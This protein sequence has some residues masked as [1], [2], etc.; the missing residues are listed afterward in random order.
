MPFR[1]ISQ[2][3]QCIVW[4]C[5]KARVWQTDRQ[6]YDSKDRARIAASRG[7]SQWVGWCVGT[8]IA[9]RR[10]PWTIL[11]NSISVVLTLIMF[12]SV[13]IISTSFE[14]LLWHSRHR[15][16]VRVD[17]CIR[18]F[19][20]IGL[21]TCLFRRLE[22][23]SRHMPGRSKC[24]GHGRDIRKTPCSYQSRDCLATSWCTSFFSTQ[25]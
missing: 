17:D 3:P 24:S 15:R 20:S 25:T 13:Q 19:T 4:F 1:V 2:Y 12:Y 18:R 7:K 21:S 11:L 10:E 6:N 22:K 16:A 14:V 23:S 8:T 9:I 5:Y